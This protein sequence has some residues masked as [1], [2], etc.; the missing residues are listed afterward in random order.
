[1]MRILLALCCAFMLL[2][3]SSDTVTNPQSTVTVTADG[4]PEISWNPTDGKTS[5]IVQFFARDG[6][7]YPI[8]DADFN[9]SLL[10]NGRLDNESLLSKNSEELEADLAL[11]LVL[12][13]SF[14][15]VQHSPPAF[16]PMIEAAKATIDEAKGIWDARPGSFTWDAVWFDQYLHRHVGT[17]KSS[18]LL[19]IPQPQAGTVTKLFAAVN[20]QAN[21]MRIAYNDGQASGPR[22]RHVMVVFTDG[23]DNYSWFNNIDTDLNKTTSAGAAYKTFGSLPVTMNDLL[24]TIP[25]HPRLT[26]HV[27]GF[28]SNVATDELKSIATAGRG[29][30]LQNPSTNQIE[31]LF[32]RVS[33]EFLTLQ[34]RGATIPLQPGDY[35]FELRV[36]SKQTGASDKL[37]FRFHAGDNTARKL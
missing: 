10:V 22:D 26:V 7:G 8:P 6:A 5:V 16:V 31:G 30:Y 28:G 19:G 3:C 15:M 18:D 33:Q 9:V 11:G 2:A 24:T 27:I 34:V 23:A 12:D 4:E 29:V 35:D 20:Y 17:W 32:D 36:T 21:R 37:S 1:M 13:S 14:S 25:T